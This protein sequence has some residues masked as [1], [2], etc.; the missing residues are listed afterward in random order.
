MYVEFCCRQNSWF[1]VFYCYFSFS[2]KNALPCHLPPVF[3]ERVCYHSTAFL[4]DC[5]V[6]FPQMLFYFSFIFD[7]HFF[8]YNVQVWFSF[9]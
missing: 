2:I 6:V 8:D 1:S 3:L 4:L 9:Y 7:L 5:D